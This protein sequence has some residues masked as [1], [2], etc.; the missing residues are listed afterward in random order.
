[1]KS[2][3]HSREDYEFAVRAS[4]ILFNND[5]TEILKQLN[6]DQLLQV[7]EGVPSGEF[8]IAE[9]QSGIDVVSFL[10]ATNIFPSKGEA[11]K[12]VQGGGVSINKMKVETIDH[13]VNTT[14]LLNGK[15]LL[16]QKGKKTYNL[17]K[18]V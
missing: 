14:A 17:V 9:L 7:L 8:S 15:Y 5:T 11:R 16:V 13:L 3:V 10:A 4:G 6:E 1:M 18:A 2:F 12:M